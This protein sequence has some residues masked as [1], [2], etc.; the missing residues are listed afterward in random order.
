[1]V[2]VAV[3]A[4]DGKKGLGR[5]CL[6]GLGVESVSLCLCYESSFLHKALSITLGLSMVPFVRT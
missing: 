5:R 3:K 6:C 2:A 1:M 4:D